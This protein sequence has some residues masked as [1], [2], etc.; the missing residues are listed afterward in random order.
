MLSSYKIYEKK[1]RQKKTFLDFMHDVVIQLITLKH[2]APYPKELEIDDGGSRFSG[3]HFPSSK[4][5]Q[6]GAVDKWPSKACRVCSAKGKRTN[7]GG[8]LK[9]TFICIFCPSEPGLQQDKCFKEYHTK[10]DYSH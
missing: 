2:E 9:A 10:S 1:T 5:S 6:P 3:R 8:Y 4:V 7:K